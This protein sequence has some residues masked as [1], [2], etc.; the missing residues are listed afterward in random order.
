MQLHRLPARSRALIVCIVWLSTALAFQVFV[1]PEAVT[2]TDLS[3]IQQRI[4]WLFL[5]P[6]MA[7]AG[8]AEALAW[9][10][11]FTV[12]GLLVSLVCLSALSIN[13]LIVSSRRAFVVMI[14]INAVVLAIAVIY[15]IRFSRLPS[16]G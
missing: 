7:A 5:T 9:P 10:S 2:V 13:T 15:F 1:K 6:M 12:G 4:Q 16:A 11:E 14:C 3:E 8:L